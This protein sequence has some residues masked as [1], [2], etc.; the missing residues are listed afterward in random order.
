MIS[1]GKLKYKFGEDKH[2]SIGSASIIIFKGELF[3]A[4]AAHCLYDLKTNKISRDIYLELKKNKK[5]ENIKISNVAIPEKWKST[6]LLSYDYAFG[7]ISSPFEMDII[8]FYPK[9]DFKADKSDKIIFISGYQLKLF[10]TSL[11]TKS[12]L[13]DSK[14]FKYDGL[15]SIKKNLKTGVSGGPWYFKGKERNIQ[16]GV[17]SAKIKGFKKQIW[18]PVWNENTRY[19]LEKLS[20]SDKNIL[21]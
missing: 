12:N 19:L 3:V 14:F 9:F 13:I 21:Y 5:I 8:P 1:V 16:I 7:K 11:I 6:Q 4:T 17:T 20:K 2:E 10:S 15:I 18:A